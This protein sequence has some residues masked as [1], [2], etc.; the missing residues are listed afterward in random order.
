MLMCCVHMSSFSVSSRLNITTVHF[1]TQRQMKEREGVG[2]TACALVQLKEREGVGLT[3]C[4]LVQ[5]K[6][7][8]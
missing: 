8:A 4:T 7:R 5:L 2:L 6:E 3:A 1:E